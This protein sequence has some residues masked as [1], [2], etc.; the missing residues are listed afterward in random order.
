ME[1]SPFAGLDPSRLSVIAETLRG[2]RHAARCDRLPHYTGGLESDLLDDGIDWSRPVRP[3]ESGRWRS[4]PSSRC[5]VAPGAP[6]GERADS[7]AWRAET[8]R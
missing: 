5:A 3:G 6:G 1:H 7:T 2:F 4:W 8:V